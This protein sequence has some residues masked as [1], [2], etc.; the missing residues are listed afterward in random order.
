MRDPEGVV[1]FT[2]ER[3]VR[4]LW[5]PLDDGHF[6]RSD[7]AARW[8]RQGSMVPFEFTGPL[9]LQ[10]PRLPFVS[11]PYEWC[12]AQLHDAAV[13]TLQLQKEATAAGFDAKD[14][15]AWN[16]LFD[17][18]RPVFC[19]LLSFVPLAERNWHALGQFV[20]HFVLP[21]QVSKQRGLRAFESFAVWR[22]GM[23]PPVAREMLGWQRYLTRYWPLVAGRPTAAPA[24][25]PVPPVAARAAESPAALAQFRA[26]LHTSLDWWLAGTAPRAGRANGV[27]DGYTDSRPHYAEEALD[28]K[29][30]VVGE[31]IGRARPSWVADLGCNTGEFSRIAT[32][33]GAEVIAVDAD[34][35]SVQRLYA[36]AGGRRLHTVVSRLDDL[37]GG[38]GWAGAEHP[39]L[40]QRMSQSVDLVLML[41]LLHHLV[42][43]ASIPLPEVVQLVRCLSRRWVIVEWLEA[44]DPQ[45]LLLCGQRARDPQ[46]FSMAAQKA[47][48]LEGGFEL[49]DEVSLAPARRTLALLK[50][51]G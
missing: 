40:V 2:P 29:R 6:V 26:R 9:E 18:A 16:V 28:R 20:R 34:H 22:D 25:A 50:A 4:T 7:L 11:H 51:P 12:D 38:R 44:D 32:E 15:S 13:L 24:A 30:A 21:L 37:A 10:S 48:F 33:G 49:C 45:V 46:E 27:W 8:V 31:W 1:R 3:V 14:A 35:D 47:A 41:A 36:G 23:P 39:G 19:D 17:G 43:G 5:R 42:I